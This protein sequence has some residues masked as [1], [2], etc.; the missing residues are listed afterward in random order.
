MDN[1]KLIKHRDSPD[2]NNTVDSNTL[3]TAF[4]KELVQ[5]A[6]QGLELA[7]KEDTTVKTTEEYIQQ[8]VT[9]VTDIKNRLLIELDDKVSKELLDA[10]VDEIKELG[11]DSIERALL[12]KKV[13][14][15]QYALDLGVNPILYKDNLE[16]GIIYYDKVNKEWVLTTNNGKIIL[17]KNGT[18]F[19]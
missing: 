2:D 5:Q 14:R 13:F 16:E 17:N 12:S 18:I 10:T 15:F 1:V 9:M 11:R 7:N 4:V 6:K 8:I 19:R 3:F